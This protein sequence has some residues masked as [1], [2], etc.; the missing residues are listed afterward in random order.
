MELL[1]PESHMHLQDIKSSPSLTGQKDTSSMSS[2]R[3][4]LLT[5]SNLETQNPGRDTII[6]SVSAGLLFNGK[7]RIDL[8]CHYRSE[9]PGK[10]LCPTIPKW[11]QSDIHAHIS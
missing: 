11:V 7:A 5:K 10:P 8:E 6:P 3:L 9:L 4:N 1:M 2:I